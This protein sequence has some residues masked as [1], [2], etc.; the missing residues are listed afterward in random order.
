MRALFAKHGIAWANWDFREGF[1]TV[2]RDGSLTRAGKAL[3]Q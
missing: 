1:A 2:E 3:L